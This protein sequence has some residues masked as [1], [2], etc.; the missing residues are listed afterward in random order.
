MK[1]LEKG[2]FLACFKKN[3]AIKRCLCVRF[4]KNRQYK[5]TK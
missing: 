2:D 3:S 5:S 1:V 4:F